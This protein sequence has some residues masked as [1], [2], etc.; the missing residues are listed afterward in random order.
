M[1]F[2]LA[3]PLIVSLGACGGG[4]G[5]GSDASAG[6]GGGGAGSGG[7]AGLV[8]GQG[9]TAPLVTCGATATSSIKLESSTLGA[10]Q[11]A[12]DGPAIVERSTT[13][14]LILYFQPGGGAGMGVTVASHATI[15]R[16]DPMPIFPVGAKVWLTKNPAKE[17]IVFNPSPWSIAVRDRQG[18]ALLFGAVRS[19]TPPLTSPVMVSGVTDD[20]I[21]TGMDICA[22]NT[23]VT[24]QTVAIQGDRAFTVR[25]GET[26]VVTIGGIDYDVSVVA[27]HTFTAPSSTP[28]CADSYGPIG[29]SLDVRAR[30][31]ASLIAGLEVGA[32]PACVMGNDLPQSVSISL[33]GSDRLAPY[34]LSISYLGRNQTSPDELMFSASAA[35]SGSSGAMPTISLY[36]PG[37]FPE[38]TVGQA[39]WV[40]A[41]EESIKV[42]RRSPTTPAIVGTF[43]FSAASRSNIELV[44]GTTVTA[45]SCQY[46]FADP[47][48]GTGSQLL[49]EVLFGTPAVRVKTGSRGAIQIAGRNYDV[50]LSLGGYVSF[51]ER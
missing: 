43:G 49:W 27:Q 22:R 15:T 10:K 42:I 1:R 30:N 33:N 12:Y 48:A 20:C 45:E 26:A 50:W 17:P 7:G 19:A 29:V 36:A 28:L 47:N 2:S 31:L 32:L 5:A 3:V 23:I 37:I 4:S 25:D 24:H 9:G 18:G 11:G 51:V 8:G 40:S 39:F 21:S 46:A 38:P 16:M 41:P 44:M 14:D 6:S 35:A 13:T 34:E